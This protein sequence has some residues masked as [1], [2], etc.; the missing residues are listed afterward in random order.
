VS[1]ENPGDGKRCDHCDAPGVPYTYKG[2]AQSG[3]IANQGERLCPGCNGR[4]HDAFVADLVENTP[5][6]VCAG[7]YRFA[8]YRPPSRKKKRD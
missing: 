7:R 4:K 6:Y 5:V 8:D 3:L 1:F 2:V